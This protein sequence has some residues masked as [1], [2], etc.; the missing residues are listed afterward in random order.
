MVCTCS[1]P[2][3]FQRI[4]KGSV[5]CLVVQ[6]RDRWHGAS[7]NRRTLMDR[8]SHAGGFMEAAGSGSVGS[9]WPREKCGRG[10]RQTSHGFWG[11]RQQRFWS[12]F[13]YRMLNVNLY[14][15]GFNSQ[16]LS[17]LLKW[18]FAI[19]LFLSITIPFLVSTHFI[20]LVF[21]YLKDISGEV[22]SFTWKCAKC[23]EVLRWTFP[24]FPAHSCP[25]WILA[26][27]CSFRVFQLV[28]VYSRFNGT[29]SCQGLL[30][31][32]PFGSFQHPSLS[33]D[34]TVTSETPGKPKLTLLPTQNSWGPWACLGGWA[35]ALWQ[36]GEP[37]G[38]VLV[39]KAVQCVPATH[40]MVTQKSQL[41]LLFS[42]RETS[43]FPRSLMC[44]R[45]R[46]L[47]PGVHYSM[48]RGQTF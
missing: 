28:L 5:V 30:I 4:L 8:R 14:K 26:F 42:D 46:C 45:H 29:F 7:R 32:H 33:Q 41:S 47:K 27:I 9:D 13:C 44:S 25:I 40:R 3:Q 18:R 48:F 43:F 2:Y 24:A 39:S 37:L 22:E 16:H 35:H 38:R 31:T 23:S 19:S 10:R 1:V 15:Q 34:F 17:T 6:Q 36:E 21:I 12:F 11:K 20:I